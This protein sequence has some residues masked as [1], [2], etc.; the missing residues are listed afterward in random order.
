MTAVHYINNMGGQHSQSCNQIAKDIWHFCLGQNISLE[1]AFISGVENV[2]A[3]CLSRLN[4]NT[5]LSLNDRS[6]N[7]IQ[8]TVGNI[9]VDLFASFKNNKC[10]KYVSWKPDRGAYNVNVFTLNWSTFSKAYAFPPFS[11]IGR[12]LQK[13]SMECSANLMIV[14]PRMMSIIKNV[15]RLPR[16]PLTQEHPLGRDLQLA[17]GVI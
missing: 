9:D 14:Y 15:K 3:D 7:M 12:V 1:T 13:A 10:D 6:F 2:K 11:L 8:A 5:E 16:N 17:F 4:S